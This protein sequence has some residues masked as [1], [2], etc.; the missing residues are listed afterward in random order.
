VRA[1][2][3]G[4]LAYHEFYGL[5]DAYNERLLATFSH[6]D[7]VQSYLFSEEGHVCK[8]KEIQYTLYSDGQ[9]P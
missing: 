6:Q 8:K 1:K 9:Q 3:R 5:D 7:D 2:L 4:R